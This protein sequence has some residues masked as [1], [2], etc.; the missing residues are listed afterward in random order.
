MAHITDRI[1][2]SAQV[3]KLLELGC[4]TET[5]IEILISS[6][7]FGEKLVSIN[8]VNYTI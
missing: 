4:T 2:G 5:N 7:H 1:F 8:G 3:K 6:A